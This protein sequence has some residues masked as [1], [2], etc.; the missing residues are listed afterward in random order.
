MRD[1]VEA[2]PRLTW[3]GPREWSLSCALYGIEV[4]GQP[5]AD[6]SDRLFRERGMVFRPFHTQGLDSMRISPNVQTSDAEIAT[7]LE[8]VGA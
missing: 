1:A 8:A 2:S 5:S 4:N 6:L 3:H 7:F